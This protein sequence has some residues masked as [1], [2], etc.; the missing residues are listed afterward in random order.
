VIIELN[1]SWRLT[2][3]EN[4]WALQRGYREKKTGQTKWEGVAYYRD[5]DAALF[6]AARRQIGLT[7]GSYG[8]EALKPLSGALTEM[9][10]MITKALADFK[11]SGQ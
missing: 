3:D 5:F 6:D 11:G 7:C 10:E 4:Q 1:A 9:K 8:P 2:S